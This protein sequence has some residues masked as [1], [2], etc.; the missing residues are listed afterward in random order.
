MGS[1]IP[2]FLDFRR[3]YQ[4]EYAIPPNF[5]AS[6]GYEAMLVLAAA[7]QKTG[8]IASGLS[9]SLLSIQK[10]NGLIGPLSF[11]PYGEIQR[12]AYLVQV[13]NGVFVTQAALATSTP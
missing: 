11:D 2:A 6:Q 8:G 9:Q 10:F 4:A 1:Q 13:K 12:P 7:L 5:A 3:R